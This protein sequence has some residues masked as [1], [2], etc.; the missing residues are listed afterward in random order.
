MRAL[1]SGVLLGWFG[2]LALRP[3]TLGADRPAPDQATRPEGQAIAPDNLGKVLQSLDY[4]PQALGND[5]YII[6]LKRGS[7]T[8]A[9]VV[10]LS[11][12]KSYLWLSAPLSTVSDGQKIA[13]TVWLRLLQ[14]NEQIGPAHFA[15]SQTQKRLYLLQPI[16]NR[17]LTPENLRSR[18][19]GFAALIVRTSPLWDSQKWASA[20]NGSAAAAARVPDGNRPSALAVE[21]YLKT[22][23]EAEDLPGMKQVQD[24]RNRGADRGDKTFAALGGL[25]SGMTAWAAQ[26]DKQLVFDRVVDIRWV[27]PTAAAARD[28]LKDQLTAMAEGTPPV[29][30]A[31][32]IGDETYVFG[33]IYEQ[34]GLGS[35]FRSY[36]YVFRQGN[37]VVKFYAAEYDPQG[38]LRP[39]TM[40]PFCQK[41]AE[42]IKA[43]AR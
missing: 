6:K 30:N 9:I 1:W 14:E 13:G 7:W 36:I 21:D 11:S 17:A 39:L 26:G 35:K 40:A 24:S 43:A 10:S 5:R 32:N 41:I 12:S 2:L 18:L 25:Y 8:L 37:V 27:F 20:A 22:Y 33:G 28:Y 38:R 23:L 31:P 4:Q 29:K 34:S 19:E 15:Y 3:A 16:E 42:R